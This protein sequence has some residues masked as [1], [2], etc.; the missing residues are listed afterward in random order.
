M[1]LRIDGLRAFEAMARHSDVFETVRADATKA[2]QTLIKKDLKSVG[3]E[4][5]RDTRKAFG[6]ETFG[7]VADEADDAIL[8]AVL[9][10]VD[11]QNKQVQAEDI[12]GKRQRFLALAAGHAEPLSKPTAVAGAAKKIAAPRAPRVERANNSAAMKAVRKR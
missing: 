2:A 7:L 10:K 3:L 8:K 4:S 11:P 1:P 5:L 9:K 12:G 6:E